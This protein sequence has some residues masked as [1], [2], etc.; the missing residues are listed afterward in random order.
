MPSCRCRGGNRSCRVSRP[1]FFSAV[2]E[3]RINVG[4]AW[5]LTIDRRHASA[6]CAVEFIARR[7]N[8]CNSPHRITI[9]ASRPGSLKRQKSGKNSTGA[10]PLGYRF[11]GR[12][13]EGATRVCRRA[14]FPPLPERR[15]EIENVPRTAAAC[16]HFLTRTF[17]HR[18]SQL[19][20]FCRRTVCEDRLSNRRRWPLKHPS[21]GYFA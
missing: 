15:I 16:K 11:G 5:R 6:P 8:S 4:F 21:F 3:R 14:V 2:R 19:V 13:A 10:M 20:C 18:A 9:S 17:L 12:A 7:L 1:N